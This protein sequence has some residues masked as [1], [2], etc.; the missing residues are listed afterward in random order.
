MPALVDL[1]KLS[2][3]VKNYVVKKDGYNAKRK[4][5]VDKI[6][7]ITNLTTKTTLNAKIN[8]VKGKIPSIINLATTAA[9]NAKINEVKC[10]IPNITNLA[11]TAVEYKIPNVS[12]LLKKLTITQK[13]MK[14]KTKLLIII[15]INILLL[16]N[17]II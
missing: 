3:A 2:D 17:L 13:L 8:K 9:L 1:S 12:N 15:M 4:S 11:S 10:K 6:P 16:W 5:I 7:D 14:L